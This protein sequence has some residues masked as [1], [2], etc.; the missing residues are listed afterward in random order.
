LNTLGKHLLIDLYQCKSKIIDQRLVLEKELSTCI[1]EAG[2]T[3][4]QSHFHDFNP[5]GT[6]GVIVLKESHLA[7]HT[8][9]EHSF[10]SID[11]FTCQDSIDFESFTTNVAKLLDSQNFTKKNLLRGQLIENIE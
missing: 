8:W 11:L 9:P 6:S 1:T 4:V 2:A 3:I 5:I 7:I 10:V